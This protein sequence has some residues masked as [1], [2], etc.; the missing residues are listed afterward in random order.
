[1]NNCKPG[2]STVSSLARRVRE[3]SAVLLRDEVVHYSAAEV[4]AAIAEVLEPVLA[5][6]QS[7]KEML[8]TCHG[9]AGA[10]ALAAWRE[11]TKE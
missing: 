1:M 9:C 2:V 10:A 7:M 6:G 5:A 11:A 3:A 4:E 8:Q